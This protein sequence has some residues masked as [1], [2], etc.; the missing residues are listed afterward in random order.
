MNAIDE[1]ALC[2]ALRERLKRH[3]KIDRRTGCWLWTGCCNNLGYGKMTLTI[4]G[5]KKAVSVHRVAWFAWQV[6]LKLH[7]GQIIYRTCKN[8]NCFN[9][10]HLRRGKPRDAMRLYQE[11]QRG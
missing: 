2:E 5:K 3:R 10:D 9:P 6:G 8:R 4:R 1:L 7:K 11:R